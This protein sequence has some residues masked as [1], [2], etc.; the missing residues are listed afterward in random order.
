M[1]TLETRMNYFNAYQNALITEINKVI[2]FQD[3]PNAP[4][5]SK[6]EQQICCCIVNIFANAGVIK[7]YG[8]NAYMFNSIF[9]EKLNAENMRN[10]I[11]DTAYKSGI[12]L[13]AKQCTWIMNEII[14]RT[15]EYMGIPNDE[16]YTLFQNVYVDNQTGQPLSCIPDYFPTMCVEAEYLINQQISV[17]CP[18]PYHPTM[19]MFLDS[20]T[21]GD[22]ILIK[23][24]W[25]VTGYCIA[26]DAM[27]KRIFLLIGESGDNGKSTYLNLLASLISR[28]AVTQMNITNLVKGWFS[29]GELD[30]RRL[31]ISADEGFLELTTAQIAELKNISGHDWISC[32]V[33]HKNQ[34]SFLCTCKILIASNNNI[35]AAYTA[36]DPA[37]TRRI[38][39]LP[40][41]VRIPKEQQDPL[42]LQKLQMEINS[43]A[44]EA[45]HHFV[46]V[47]NRNYVFTGDD[48]YD[49]NFNMYPNNPLYSMIAEFSSNSCCFQPD[50][51]SYTADLY[52]AFTSRYGNE[53]F[54]DVT[55]F[56]QAFYKANEAALNKHKKH[57]SEKYA[58]GFDGVTLKE[59]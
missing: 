47:R 39:S 28:H 32:D 55:G 14:L 30:L 8:G 38:C 48:I 35:G 27:A 20:I 5:N 41:D 52:D 40:F 42:L 6:Q 36:C 19:D 2:P 31:E 16:R 44:T 58:W 24:F 9:Y 54:K 49:K 25:E 51:Y 10:F 53:A 26:S 3:K 4:V 7:R 56:S 46:E 45:F 1:N 37:F 59:D 57:T 11:F 22:P 29:L 17:F 43:I 18:Q 21:G 13:N 50:A 23:R 33:K 34:S 12:I 15:P